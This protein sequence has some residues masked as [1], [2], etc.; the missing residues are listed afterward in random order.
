[1]LP[2]KASIHVYLENRTRFT[3]A[4]CPE[5]YGKWTTAIQYVN[6]KS[7]GIWENTVHTCTNI[8]VRV[9]IYV[10]VCVHHV[11]MYTQEQE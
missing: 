2:V 5:V 10:Y 4:A 3:G 8:H 1:M 6:F 11:Y 7:Y 9:H